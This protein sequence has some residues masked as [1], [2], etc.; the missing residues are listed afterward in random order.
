[1][2]SAKEAKKIAEDVDSDPITRQLNRI[3]T[4]INRQVRSGI[5]HVTF[6]PEVEGFD[7]LYKENLEVLLEHG[8]TL[9]K[10]YDHG[11]HAHWDISW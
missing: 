1:M 6:S 4:L 5:Y 3:E 8:F 10:W 11:K 7:K 2:I 9:Q